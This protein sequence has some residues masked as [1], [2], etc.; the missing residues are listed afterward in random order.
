MRKEE[1]RKLLE[2]QNKKNTSSNFFDLRENDYNLAEKN[3][4][5]VKSNFNISAN[6]GPLMTNDGAVES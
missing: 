5:F 1:P 3:E 6:F 4:F 2:G